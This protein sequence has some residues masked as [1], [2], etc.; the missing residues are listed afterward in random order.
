[1]SLGATTSAPASHVADRGPA[2]QLQR[3]VVRH[4]AV[5]DHAAMA[6]RR[7]LAETDVR[8]QDE[9]RVTLAQARSARWTIPSDAYAPDP[10]SSFSSGIPKR[11][12]GGQPEPEQ[13]LGLA[14]EIVDRE[15]AERRQLLVRLA[16]GPDEER[17]DEIGRSSFVSRTSER[18]AP[19]R[20]SLRRR[21]S[22]N[23]LTGP[24]YA[25]GCSVRGR[26]GLDRAGL[27]DVDL[28]RHHSLLPVLELDALAE[29][30]L[31]RPEHS[32]QR[33]RDE[34]PG[35]AVELARRRGG[36]R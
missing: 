6:V 31:D 7:V 11:M 20:R 22:G 32:E 21:V 18:S 25:S 35:Q 13:L 33:Q 24:P 3:R 5:L 10:S 4:L 14:R 36:R 34:D 9:I 17:I 29:E 1:M 19:V 30:L 23:E 26:H 16:R 8:D 15:A 27:F 12:H 28:D 2:E